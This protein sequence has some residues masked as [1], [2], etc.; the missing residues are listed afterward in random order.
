MKTGFLFFAVL[1]LILTS[2]TNSGKTDSQHI[3]T[4][5]KN[6]STIKYR[7][8]SGIVVNTNDSK[9]MAG[10]IISFNN[11]LKNKSVGTLTDGEG[12][13]LLDSIPDVVKKITVVDVSK[14]KSKEVELNEKDDIL[15][16]MEQ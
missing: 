2:C 1:S 6:N 12:K 15:I 3:S 13:F 10:L 4:L 7:R 5:T 9:P 8:I 14:N 11:P 16:K